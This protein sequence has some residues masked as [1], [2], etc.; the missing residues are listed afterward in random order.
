MKQMPNTGIHSAK[1]NSEQRSG[2]GEAVATRFHSGGEPQA[3]EHGGAGIEHFADAERSP[4]GMKRKRDQRWH[5][6]DKV[7]RHEP[8][9]DGADQR[10]PHIRRST[11]VAEPRP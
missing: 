5:D 4:S 7:E 3:T 9:G 6:D 10:R 2:Q 1:V 8:D 11:D